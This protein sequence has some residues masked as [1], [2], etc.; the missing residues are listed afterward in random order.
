MK[1]LFDENDYGTFITLQ[2]ET[3][4]EVSQLFRMAKNSKKQPAD[5]Y[6][7]FDGKQPEAH[8]AFYKVKKEKQ[9]NSVSK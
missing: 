9:I 1:L 6:M 2:P 8:V 7:R 3:M 4:E 5:I